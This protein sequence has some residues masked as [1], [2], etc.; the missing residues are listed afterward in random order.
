MKKS[1]I[2]LAG[3]CFFFIPLVSFFCWG[4][5]FPKDVKEEERLFSVYR[6][7]GV[8]SVAN[9]LED[10]EIIKKDYFFILYA[11]LTK[12]NREIKSGN[13]TFSSSMSVAEIMEKLVDGK[14][15]KITI[16]EGWNLKNIADLL[17]EKGYGKKEDFFRVAGTPPFY[18][19]GK[20]YP[21]KKAEIKIES[22]FLEKELEKTTLEGYLFPDTYYISPGTSMEEII[23]F[24]LKN[25]EKKITPEIKEMMG[26]EDMSLFETITIAS[27]IEKEV[28]SF[29]DKKI[30]SG[31]IK[32]RLQKNMRLQIDAT[33]TYLTEKKSLQV[34]L[35]E[36]KIDSPYNTYLYS[37]L[38]KGPI[39]NPGT[40]SIFAA[41]NPEESDYLYYLS[42][43]N[44]ETVFSKT[45]EEHVEAKRKYL[46]NN[47]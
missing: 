30:V 43:P 39:C 29:E 34:S 7:E 37:G 41:L 8:F 18:N 4:V 23:L 38:P 12:K 14:A 22:T 40:E 27:L 44:G 31:I 24:F 15:E 2:I 25:F 16:I 33:I 1:T 35:L 11:V 10:M 3:I 19:N 17:E 20:V 45:H 36:T 42:R 13:Y 9:N 26:K 21:E 6:G 5:Y 28:T 47:N 32:K 46:K